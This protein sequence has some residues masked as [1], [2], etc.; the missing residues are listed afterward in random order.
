M[1][2]PMKW[3]RNKYQTFYA[4]IKFHLG[5]GKDQSLSIDKGE[6]FEY[7]GTVIKY[8]GTEFANPRLR[9][10]YNQG[11]FTLDQDERRVAPVQPSRNVARS[12]TKNDDLSRVQRTSHMGRESLDEETVL[13]VQDRQQARQAGKSVGRTASGHLTQADNRRAGQRVDRMH[14]E[15]SDLDMQDHVVVGRVNSPAKLGIVDMTQSSNYGLAKDIENRPV[16][17]PTL[18]EREGVSIKMNVGNVDSRIREDIE[19]TG[20]VV[21]KV[22]KTA[23]GTRS[24]GGVEVLDTSGP[25]G[26]RKAQSVEIDSSL[27][28]RIRVARRIDPS[29]PADWVFSGKLADR[30]AAVKSHG[31]TPAFLEA[32]YA[33][34]GD[35]MRKKLEESFPKQFQAR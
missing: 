5:D 8:A 35:Q 21:G 11:W 31:A 33:A 2:E 4:Q 28:P 29:F 7:D 15:Q 27:P 34:E 6:E 26:K 13:H 20:R 14:V 32:L 12:Q 30:L 24:A 3:E 19:D 10:A 22:R 1:N 23:T 18:I 16:G 25:A 17:R 9:G